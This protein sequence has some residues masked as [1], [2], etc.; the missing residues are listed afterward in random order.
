[1]KFTALGLC[2]LLV[3]QTTVSFGQEAQFISNLPDTPT[4]KVL[5]ER[6]S[7]MHEEAKSFLTPAR[8]QEWAL[9]SQLQELP[10]GIVIRVQLRDDTVV[11]GVL[12]EV[13]AEGICLTDGR[14]LRFS[15]LLMAQSQY[16]SGW[17]MKK[18]LLVMAAFVGGLFLLV[19][20]GLRYSES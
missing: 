15:E 4:A 1:M 11:T 5:R 8:V 3:F 2:L 12:E 9:R 14:Q 19:Y 7:N 18:K 16:Y 17:S 6:I 13:S 20:L 10:T